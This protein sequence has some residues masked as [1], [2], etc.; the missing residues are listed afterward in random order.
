MFWN[1]FLITPRIRTKLVFVDRL[2]PAIPANAKE[3]LICS[4]YTEHWSSKPTSPQRIFQFPSASP[5]SGCQESQMRQV[6]SSTANGHSIPTNVNRRLSS[7]KRRRPQQGKSIDHRT[8][9]AAYCNCIRHWVDA[10]VLWK[11]LLS[12]CDW[13][14]NAQSCLRFTQSTRIVSAFAFADKIIQRQCVACASELDWSFHAQ[15]SH[16]P[17][18]RIGCNSKQSRPICTRSVM[19]CDRYWPEIT[20][21]RGS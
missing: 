5:G 19:Q 18:Y 12:V 6:D 8:P 3:I 10:L 21:Y 4:A 14:S 1:S 16:W 13:E 9:R 2:T 17:Q 11:Y 15:L 7:F 20:V